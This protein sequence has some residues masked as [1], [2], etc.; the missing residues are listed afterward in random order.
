MT[1]VQTCALPICAIDLS[2]NETE[3]SMRISFRVDTLQRAVP[4]Y[5]DRYP[6]SGWKTGKAPLGYGAAA[7]N[8]TTTT[9]AKTVYCVTSFDLTQSPAALGLLVKCHDGAVV[10]LN[11]EELLIYNMPAGHITHDTPAVSGIKTNQI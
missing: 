5:D 9:T 6:A 8:T 2:G 7:G 10:Y 11:G 3:N 1:G 4:W